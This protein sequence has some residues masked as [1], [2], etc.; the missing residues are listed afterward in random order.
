VIYEADLPED[1]E[2]AAI[3]LASRAWQSYITAPPEVRLG[4]EEQYAH[5]IITALRDVGLTALKAEEIN[6]IGRLNAELFPQEVK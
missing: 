4:D 3:V 5:A 2:S 6:S 1:T